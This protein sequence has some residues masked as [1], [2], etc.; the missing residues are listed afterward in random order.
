MAMHFV[1][2]MTNAT[3]THTEYIIRIVSAWQQWLCKHASILSYIVCLFNYTSKPYEC[4]KLSQFWILGIVL[5][6]KEL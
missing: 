4:H 5:K 3:N 2:W 6:R 1:C